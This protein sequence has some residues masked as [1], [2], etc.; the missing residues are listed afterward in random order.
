[1]NLMI[2]YLLALLITILV[3]FVII[4][5]FI[6]KEPSKLF[7][8]SILM[9]SFTLPIAT[10]GYQDILNNLFVIE[11]L[12][13]FAESILIMLLLRIRYVKALC[14][15]FIANLITALISLLFFL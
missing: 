5:V 3:E 1:M 6:R 12:V 14:I 2:Q 9:N 10:Y 13:V 15:S 4:W 8:Y 7:L 11:I